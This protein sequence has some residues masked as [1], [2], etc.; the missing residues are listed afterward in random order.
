MCADACPAN[1]ITLKDD[2]AS[3]D[4]KKCIGC[5]SCA[6]VCPKAAIVMTILTKQVGTV[7]QTD[8]KGRKLP[9]FDYDKCIRCFC[10]ME[11]CPERAIQSRESPVSKMLRGIL[12]RIR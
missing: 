10:C 1:A 7:R 5:A 2:I 3:I 4:D 6:D 11:V 12:S 9:V 8:G